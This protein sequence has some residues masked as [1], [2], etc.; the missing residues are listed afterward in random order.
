MSV[1]GLLGTDDVFAADLHGAAPASGPGALG[2]TNMRKVLSAQP[3][4]S[5]SHRDPEAC[6]RVQDAYS[7]RCAPQVAGGGP[8]HHRPRRARRRLR[9]RVG[10]RQPRRHRSTAGSSPTATSTARRSA[11]VLDFLAIAAA[12]L[13][14]I[15]ER[16]TDRL[17]DRA[18]THGL[19][20]FLAE[21]AGRR[22]AG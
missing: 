6:T 4:P 16:R 18:R 13:A 15:S 22:L 3:D 17:L 1:E 7:L 12:D 14:S 5:S 21:D 20:P 19:P 8:R 11:Y 9:A 2:A 10:D